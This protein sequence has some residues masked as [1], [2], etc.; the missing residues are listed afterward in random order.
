MQKMD[1]RATLIIRPG[2]EDAEMQATEQGSPNLPESQR[3][4]PQASNPLR[5]LL[6]PS[7]QGK[8]ELLPAY[9]LTHVEHL[10]TDIS[11]SLF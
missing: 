11:D 9:G 2:F 3:K 1:E 6:E 5:H 8:S 4:K 10:A 7:H